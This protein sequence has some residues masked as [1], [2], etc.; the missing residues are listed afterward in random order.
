M[1]ADRAPSRIGSALALGLATAFLYG[2]A[3]APFEGAAPA[4]LALVPL[5]VAFAR[6]SLLAA[7]AAGLVFGGAATLAVGWWLPGTLERDFEVPKPA[8]WSAFF[9]A[10]LWIDGL[11]YAA[12]GAWSARLARRGRAPGAFVLGAG[13]VWAEWLRTSGP[14]ANP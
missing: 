8:A 10:A 11:P 2:A 13:F 6:G 5:F 14:V 4:W 7:A 12:L 9:A 3:Y 1:V